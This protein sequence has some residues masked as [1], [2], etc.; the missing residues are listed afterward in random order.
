MKIT[1]HSSSGSIE[2]ESE[3]GIVTLFNLD[4]ED[5]HKPSPDD[6][7]E[8]V[9][10][11]IEEYERTYGHKPNHDVDILDIGYWYIDGEYEEPCFD[12][13]SDRDENIAEDNG[14]FSKAHS[15]W[16]VIQF[17]TVTGEVISAIVANTKDLNGDE[18]YL[19]KIVRLDVDEWR[20][21]HKTEQ[22][23]S[24]VDIVDFGDW[25]ADGEYTEPSAEHRAIIENYNHSK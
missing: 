2:F 16:G 21:Y 23:P 12:W 14:P 15:N 11:D 18:N 7:K 1:A 24:H 25:T 13:R 3:T 20:K 4:K 6:Y 22:I 5:D 8:I 9:K 10:V 17:N 19:L